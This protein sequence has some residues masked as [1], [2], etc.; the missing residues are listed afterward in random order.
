MHYFPEG[1][2]AIISLM[3]EETRGR[4]LGQYFYYDSTYIQSIN[5]HGSL[6]AIV[7]YK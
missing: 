6:E 3:S 4:T 5:T 7:Y 1:K 2:Y